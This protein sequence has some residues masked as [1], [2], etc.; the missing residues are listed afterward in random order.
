MLGRHRKFFDWQVCKAMGAD[1]IKW[2]D[3]PSGDVGDGD[4]VKDARR[5]TCPA[6]EA[7]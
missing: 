3:F 2:R 4:D 1:A 6:S 5:R 7:E